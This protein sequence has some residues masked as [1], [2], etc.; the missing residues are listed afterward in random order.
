MIVQDRCRVP[1]GVAL[2]V[3]KW[4]IAFWTLMRTYS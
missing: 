4:F 1:I 3:E 2:I